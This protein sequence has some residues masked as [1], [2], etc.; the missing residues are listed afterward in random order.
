MLE[1]EKSA[2]KQW[3]NSCWREL[4]IEQAIKLARDIGDIEEEIVSVV[5]RRKGVEE[6]ASTVE[7]DQDEKMKFEQKKAELLKKYGHLLSKSS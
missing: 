6:K 5:Q 3:V 2:E 7:M 1:Q 4:S